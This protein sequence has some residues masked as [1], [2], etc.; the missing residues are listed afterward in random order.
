MKIPCF[1]MR[2]GTSKGFFFLDK[3]LPANKSIRDEIILKA[4]GAGNARGVDGMGT[5][6]PLSNKIAI[7]RASTT[8]GVDIDYLFLQADLKRMILD[9]SVNCGNI[10]AAVAPYAVE[11]GLIKVGSGEKT[12][13]IRN[14]NTNVIVESTIATK[15]GNV[16]YEGDIKIDGVPGTG[17]PINLNFKNS[18]GS[19]TG[20]LFPTGEKL[21]V[22]N[23]INVSCIDVSVPLIIIRASE[24]G[25]IGDEKPEVLNANKSFLR[26]IDLI[27]KE[28]AYLANLGDVSNKVIPKIAIVS[29][30]RKSGTITSRYF[31][32]HQCHSTH[33]VTGSLA[34]SA[35]INICG[36]TAYH[37]VHHN[38]QNKMKKPSQIIIEH[39]AGKIQ[40][41]SVVEESNS[42]YVIKKSSVTRTARLLFK[43]EFILP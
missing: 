43:G 19:V 8:P 4:L 23:G 9:D 7:I 33:A 39:P 20:K 10:I 16:V 21:N 32:P 3:H 31:I 11:S 12:I 29:K 28:V 42:G 1:I 35:A 40:T 30:P 6:D 13:I 37:V 34:L 27:R 22:I 15:N 14:L 17:A 36:T 18:I 38:Y 24:L 26:N 41:E 25:I 2:G 5:L